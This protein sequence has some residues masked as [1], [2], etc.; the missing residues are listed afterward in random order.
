MIS[1]TL[2]VVF[3]AHDLRV[4]EYMS[5]RVAVMYPGQGDGVGQS[6]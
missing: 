2:T 4:V 1:G 6:Q 3:I 5:D